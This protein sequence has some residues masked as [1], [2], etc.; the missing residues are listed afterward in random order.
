ALTALGV[1]VGI[2]AIIAL[3]TISGNLKQELRAAATIT[4]GDLLIVQ[5]GLTG[6]TGSLIDESYIDRIEQQYDAV[7]RSAGFLM[8]SLSFSETSIL[9]LF[10]IR[11]EDKDMYLGDEQIISGV[12][13]RG[14]GEMGLGKLASMLLDIDVGDTVIFPSGEEFEVVGIYETGNSYLD[15]GG[16]VSLSQAQTMTNREGK[17]TMIALDVP[18]GASVDEVAQ[19]L[20]ADMPDLNVRTPERFVEATSTVKTVDVFAMVFSLIALIM[21]GIAVVNIMSISVSERTREIGVLRTIGWGRGKILRMILGEALVLSLGGFVIGGLLG[22]FTIYGVTFLPPNVRGYIIPS[23]T[24]D[25]FLV[26]LVMS[27][28]LGIIGGAYPAYKASR[29][30]PIEAL[31]YE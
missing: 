9:N 1:G 19:S 31:N 2:A 22:I 27:L 15:S 20:E 6:P 12:Y 7:E 8:E 26:A 14:Y 11:L 29:L 18:P 16:I 17:V 3:M 21:G 28:L 23:L 30:S 4:G 24:V 13:V 25:P 10:G 5:D